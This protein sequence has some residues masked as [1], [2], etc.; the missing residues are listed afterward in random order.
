MRES[1]SLRA[2]DGKDLRIEKEHGPVASGLLG[3]RSEKVER[4][5]SNEVGYLRRNPL[6][7]DG[8]KDQPYVLTGCAGD[9]HGR[10]IDLDACDYIR[11]VAD[12]YRDR[13]GGGTALNADQIRSEERRVGKEC[14]S[15]WSPYH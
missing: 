3:D 12:T 11:V 13:S 14:R 9:R 5:G 7:R 2:A 8:V 15:R 10:T 4:C 6:A 1:E